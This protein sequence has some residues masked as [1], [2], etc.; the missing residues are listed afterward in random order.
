MKLPDNILPLLD[1]DW[2]V[3]LACNAIEYPLVQQWKEKC[4]EAEERGLPLP[5]EPTPS[6]E[7]TV[8]VFEGKVKEIKRVLQTETNP[9]VFFTGANNF[10]KEVSKTK[11]YKGTRSSEKPFHYQNLTAYIEVR[12]DTERKDNLEADDLMAMFQT[13]E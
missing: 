6:F 1:G 12:F 5:P 9:I 8:D 3:Y 10:R 2:I 11:V 13:H 4:A 7:D